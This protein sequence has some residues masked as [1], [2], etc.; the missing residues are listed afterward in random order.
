MRRAP[1]LVLCACVVACGGGGHHHKSK[2]PERPEGCDVK[3][4]HEAPTMPVDDIGRVRSVC[5][6]DRISEKDCQREL[7]DQACKLGADVVWEVP[8]GPSYEDGKQLWTGR[9]AHTK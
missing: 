7:M 6:Q 1:L 3:L 4:F 2:W 5:D 8:F 9:A